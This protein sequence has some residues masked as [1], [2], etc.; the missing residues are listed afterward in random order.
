M[1]KTKYVKIEDCRKCSHYDGE[2]AGY[3]RCKR[4]NG[5]ITTALKAPSNWNP[6]IKNGAMAVRC[7][8]VE[9]DSELHDRIDAISKKARTK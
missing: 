9:Q 7:H 1:T 6:G 3:V 5:T 8:N 2:N 4:D